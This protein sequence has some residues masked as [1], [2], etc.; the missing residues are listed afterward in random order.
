MAE[1]LSLEEARARLRYLGLSHREL[2]R[3]LGVSISIVRSVLAGRTRGLYGDSHK[4]AVAL[5]I[6]EGMILPDG[7]PIYEALKVATK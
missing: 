4:V 5:G 3:R 7:Q 2:S 6:K 1:V